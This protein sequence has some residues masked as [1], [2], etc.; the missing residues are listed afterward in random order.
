MQEVAVHPLVILSVIDHHRRVL[1]GTTGFDSTHS[2]AKVVGALL[3]TASPTRS[4]VLASFAVP[5][6]E[7]ATDPAASFLDHNYMEA[8]VDLHK[9]VTA[10][11]RLLGWYK[12]V[13]PPA[14]FL[15]Q[16][17][18]DASC[19]T[20]SRS[21][22]QLAWDEGDAALARKL[23]QHYG[24]ALF[25]VFDATGQRAPQA[26]VFSAALH[27]DHASYGP[28]TPFQMLECT[29]DAE[30]AELV[31]VEHL[32]RDISEPPSGLMSTQVQRK[33][34]SLRELDRQLADLESV[35]TGQLSAGSLDQAL[36]ENVQSLLNALPDSSTT[37]SDSDR[38]N[39]Q[40]AMTLVGSLGKCVCAL[41]DVVLQKS[42]STS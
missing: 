29:I 20:A 33:V 15:G 31:G 21:L 26:F 2:R 35:L 30:E 8:M 16:T 6:E 38:I 27:S 39:E 1:G 11:E 5:F 17:D 28:S 18:N 23:S 7:D 25:V 34:Q 41:Y 14:H 3:G 13:V 36:L 4:D 32:L 9:K 24:L 40:L 12:C 42:V 22:G 19:T 10:K 37:H